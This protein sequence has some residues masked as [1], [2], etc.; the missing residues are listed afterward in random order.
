[1]KIIKKSGWSETLTCDNCA[2]QYEVNENDIEAEDNCYDKE[3]PLVWAP[4]PCC[5]FCLPNEIDGGINVALAV[6]Q[7]TCPG[8]RYDLPLSVIEK[9]KIKHEDKITALNRI[10]LL[11]GSVKNEELWS[12]INLIE[13]RLTQNNTN[14]KYILKA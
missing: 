6:K 10:G 13:T 8:Q 7:G 14:N 4:C 3:C 12:F 1:M 11:L 2:A 5:G 9:G